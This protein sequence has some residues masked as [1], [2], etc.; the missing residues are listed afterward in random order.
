MDITGTPKTNLRAL[1]PLHN[2]VTIEIPQGIGD[3]VY[4]YP[5]LKKLIQTKFR[6]KRV[7][8]YRN[9]HR[10]LLEPLKQFGNVVDTMDPNA[11]VLKIHYVKRKKEETTQYEDLCISAGLDN[12][13]NFVFDWPFTQV[14]YSEE[15]KK[16]RLPWITRP[17]LVVKEPCAAHMHKKN[18]QPSVE[19]DVKELQRF[20]DHYSAQG[21]Q[22]ISVGLDEHF[23]HR[24][25][26][27]D[28][29][30]VDSIN[31]L[32]DYITFIKGASIVLTQAGH[33]VPL[34]Q[35][36]KIQHRVFYPARGFLHIRPAKLDRLFSNVH[37]W[38]NKPSEVRK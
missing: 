35:A 5:I 24:L 33:L 28:L 4:C 18:R 29:Q 34:A 17:Y 6:N 37:Q 25:K 27:I 22:I 11:M 1:K 38:R 7:H 30:L 13:P 8:I 23:G 36:F 3:A 21:Y 14:N 31:G 16:I 15:F 10:L 26:N 2:S 20:V 12:P 9:P 32:I 19:P